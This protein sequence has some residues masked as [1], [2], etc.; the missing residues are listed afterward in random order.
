MLENKI[1][2][3]LEM[4]EL[5]ILYETPSLY[6]RNYFNDLKSKIDITFA[7]RHLNETNQIKR[8]E[9]AKFWHTIIDKVNKYEVECLKTNLNRETKTKEIQYIFDKQQ[10]NESIE[11]LIE[12]EKFKL[13]K[14]LFLN[15]T[16]FFLDKSICVNETLFDDENTIK[17]VTITDEYISDKEIEDFKRR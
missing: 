12:H 16:V 2:I 17:L 14:V 9:L 5:R 7:P 6:L 15:R 10:T 3:E 4:E 13:K 1:N 8:D 11:D